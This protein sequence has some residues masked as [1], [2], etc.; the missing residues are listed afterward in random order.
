MW[1]LK[2]DNMLSQQQG[3]T[4]TAFLN[5]CAFLFF[6]ATHIQRLDSSFAIVVTCSVFWKGIL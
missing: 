2:N 1:L 3:A 4:V 5:N 6:D